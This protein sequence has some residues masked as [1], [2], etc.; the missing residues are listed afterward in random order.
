MD[1][2]NL[3]GLEASS[4]DEDRVV[5]TRKRFGRVKSGIIR[6]QRPGDTSVVIDDADPGRR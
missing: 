1:V 3:P 6:G 5:A 4:L 2:F